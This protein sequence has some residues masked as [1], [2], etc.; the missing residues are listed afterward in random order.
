MCI[1]K[2]IPSRNCVRMQTGMRVTLNSSSSPI[3]PG[4]HAG[5]LGMLC[6][7][8]RPQ[9][10][11]AAQPMS[12]SCASPVIGSDGTRTMLVYRGTAG[13]TIGS[14]CCIRAKPLTTSLSLK[15]LPE[16]HCGR[17]LCSGGRVRQL[18]QGSQDL[19][20]DEGFRFPDYRVD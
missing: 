15:T 11:L 1:C 12:P 13:A 14:T 9:S 6:H 8:T 10:P 17:R 3:C 5:R 7:S 2:T 18:C 20:M 4:G 16:A 19:S